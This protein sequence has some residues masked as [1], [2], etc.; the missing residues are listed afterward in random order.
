MKI[1]VQSGGLVEFIG[2]EKGY[3]MIAKAGFEAIDWNSIE[4][5]CD[6]MKWREGSIYDKPLE[7]CIAYYQKEYDIIRENGLTI[8]QAHAPFPCYDVNDAEMQPYMIGVYRKMIELCQH[9]GVPRLVIHAMTLALCAKVNTPES[10]DRINRTLYESL[11]PTLQACPD[12]MVCLENLP[13][14]GGGMIEGFCSKEEEAVRWIDALN[15]KAGRQAFGLCLD[16]GHLRLMRKDYRTYIPAVGERLA[17]LHLHDNDGNDDW[18]T[19][20]LAGVIYWEHICQAL[21]QIDY[22]G[23]LSFETAAIIRKVLQFDE[24]LVQTWLNTIA[25]TGMSLRRKI[26]E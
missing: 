26:K 12:V 19:A 23:D 15:E 14:W 18:H 10:L 20:P 16:V 7:E 13:S 5:G 25:Q 4:H 24:D 17:C 8:T 2:P 9:F 22:P 21:K 3:A 1:S 11:I 6:A